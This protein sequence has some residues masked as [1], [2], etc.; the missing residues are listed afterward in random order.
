MNP[1]VT[2]ATIGV[3]GTV[4]VGVAGFGASILNTRR[5]IAHT[6]ESR[7]WDRRADSYVETLAAL[8]FRQARVRYPDRAARR[9]R[10]RRGGR[11]S[12][13]VGPRGAVALEAGVDLHRN[14]I[15]R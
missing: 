6:R 13:Q 8:H 9:D 5:T 12:R 1:V 4:I 14:R 15:A 11:Q 2:A 10:P 7:V 3:G